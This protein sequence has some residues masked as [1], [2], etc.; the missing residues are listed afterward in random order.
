MLAQLSQV[1]QP[2]QAL[3][4][5]SFT[6]KEML[7]L[8]IEPDSPIGPQDPVSL[9]P[10]HTFQKDK[11]QPAPASS[12]PFRNVGHKSR[13]KSK[14][15]GATCGQDTGNVP[16]GAK[17]GQLKGGLESPEASWCKQTQMNRPQNRKGIACPASQARVLR[18]ASCQITRSQKVLCNMRLKCNPPSPS[19]GLVE[20]HQHKCP[21]SPGKL[22]VPAYSFRFL[23]GPGT[24]LQEATGSGQPLLVFQRITTR[25]AQKKKKKGL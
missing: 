25:F 13:R 14:K 8:M 6:G 5:S 7:T 15:A 4:S 3:Q 11:R 18:F 24:G 23:V 1:L 2:R 16:P 17:S 22:G 12:V 20:F 10:T 19:I 21:C 9:H